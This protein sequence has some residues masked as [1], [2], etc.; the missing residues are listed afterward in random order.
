MTTAEQPGED[1]ATLVPTD[2]GERRWRRLSLLGLLLALPVTFLLAAR[3]HLEDW[4]QAQELFEQPVP[5]GSEVRFAGAD[6]RLETV[7]VLP[8]KQSGWPRREG[9]GTPVRVRFAVTVRDPGI[10]VLWRRCRVSLRDDQGHR[11]SAGS[12]GGPRSTE[13]TMTC[14]AATLEPRAPGTVLRIEQDFTVP[15]DAAATVE[16]TVSMD[17]ERPWYLRFRRGG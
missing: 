10:D 4:W 14:G 8:L 3:G 7:E 11:W 16:P 17:G 5:A 2:R 1:A 9:Q 12:F 15:H 13:G 6:W